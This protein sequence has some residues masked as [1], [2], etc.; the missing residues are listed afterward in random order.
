MK[1]RSV[2]A[3]MAAF[4][5]LAPAA[6]FALPT[7]DSLQR[8]ASEAARRG[9]PLVLLISL[10][11]CPYCELVRRNYLLP[12]RADGLAAWQI[13][14]NDPVQAVRDFQGQASTG[15]ALAAQ[16]KIRVTPT[17]LFFDATGA[18]IASRIEGI[19]VPDF[20][21]AYLDEALITGRKRL[22]GKS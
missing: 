15:A 11:G 18:E 8:V 16:W 13:T 19:A 5:V 10:P 2:L 1:R 7:P 6:E 3:L 21:G 14:V 22:K 12:M 9:Q 20:Y 4:P 17:V